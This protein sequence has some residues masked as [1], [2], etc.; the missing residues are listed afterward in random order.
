[1]EPAPQP[2][3]GR[4]TG[5]VNP[6]S[7]WTWSPIPTHEPLITRQL[8][9]AAAPVARTRQGSRT[10]A[11]PNSHP[12][13][14]RTYLLRSYIIHDTCGRRMHGKTRRRGGTYYACQ[15]D[16]RHHA[17][18]PWY[19]QH[20]KTVW[21]RED[22]LTAAVH[23]FFATRILGPD[24]HHHLATQLGDQHHTATDDRAR[25][26]AA[27]TKHIDD[28]RRRQAKLLEQLESDEDD[29]LDPQTRREFRKTIRDR[30][31]D[32]A[33]QIRHT[34]TERDTL[35]AA[36]AHQPAT[37]PDLLN[38]LPQLRLHL[39]HAP[40]HLQ[41]ALYDTFDLK[42]IYNRERHQA[43]LK[44]TIT[45]DTLDSLTHTINAV[46]DR[47]TNTPTGTSRAATTTDEPRPDVSHVL[48]ALDCTVLKPQPRR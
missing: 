25:R 40:E 19:P 16:A 27:L 44:I 32:L 24:R 28:R 48:R 46:A 4:R 38:R 35:Q 37:D 9:D 6:P 10:G 17:D 34:E 3:R 41:R 7:A 47:R 26:A 15:P 1:M 11:D 29:G 30:F 43:T 45:D 23:D 21:V 33:N 31:A 39:P 13:T 2:R 14:T 20:P 8:F 36:T 5:K 42:I 18:K 12:Q 22:A